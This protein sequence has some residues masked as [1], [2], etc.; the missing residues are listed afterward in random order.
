M[1]NPRIAVLLGM[2]R[3]GTSLTASILEA[4]G[5][6]FGNDF[7]PA[8]E[9]NP[10]GYFENAAITRAQVRLNRL[11]NRRPFTAAGLVDYP[12]AFWKDRQALEFVDELE[13]LVRKALDNTRGIWGFKDP[14]TIKLLPLWQIVFERLGITPLYLLA[15]RHPAEVAA[16]AVKRDHIS[17]AQGELLWIDQNVAA[18]H[19]TGFAIPVVTDYAA[20]FS[21]PLPQARRLMAALGLAWPDDDAGLRAALAD[22]ID[23][24][25][26]RQKHNGCTQSP[27][28][29]EL[30]QQLLTVSMGADL[31]QATEAPVSYYRSAKQLFDPAWNLLEREYRI[32]REKDRQLQ[33]LK[34][35]LE[36]VKGVTD[37]VAGTRS[38]AL[39]RRY[40]ILRMRISNQPAESAPLVRLQRMLEEE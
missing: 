17:A 37:A 1:T 8:D 12:Q 36:Q 33:I 19:Y 26:H 34:Y 27:F 29:R 38:G 21:D 9:Y 18:L 31:R 24:A 40:Q 28:A 15:V 10:N 25:L 5:V 35:R 16:S 11:L 3:S 20:W 32:R 6:D 30:Y 2:H 7:I 39:L 22:R 4:L 14:H 23:P 13:M